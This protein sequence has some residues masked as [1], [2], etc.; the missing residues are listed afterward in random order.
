MQVDLQPMNLDKKERLSEIVKRARGSMSKS[1]FGRLLGVS[2]TAITGWEEG[3]NEPSTENLKKIANKIGCTLGDLEKLIDGNLKVAPS[4][5]DQIAVKIRYM[6][7]K[8]F[9]VIV[10]AV[11][12]RLS[13][14]AS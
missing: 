8:E 6:P 14:I 13:A 2:H 4:E 9:A 12:D 5:V 11:G 3:L 10:R 1:A 7:E